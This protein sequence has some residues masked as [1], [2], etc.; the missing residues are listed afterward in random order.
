MIEIRFWQADDGTKFDN[1]YE[2]I[3]YERR[4]KIEECKN[5]F[6]FYDKQKNIIPLEKAYP[7]KI[8]I[9]VIKTPAVANYIGEW[10]E[11]NNCYSPFR[12]CELGY[13]VGTW[14]YGELLEMG[15]E[16]IKIEAE[17]ERLQNFLA[18]I[19]Q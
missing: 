2:C 14:V 12:D 18:E 19:K 17:I 11:D 7:E 8:D 1:K 16:W 13:E 15:D 3:Q 6:I 9:I 4:K 10:F 5:D